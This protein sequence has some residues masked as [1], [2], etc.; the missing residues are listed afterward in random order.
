LT[1][2]KITLSVADQRNEEKTIVVTRVV[3]R[4]ER[5]HNAPD[6]QSL[7]AGLRKV[8]TM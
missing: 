5:R 7:Y 2:I 1:K 4:G 8:L 6:A 3:T